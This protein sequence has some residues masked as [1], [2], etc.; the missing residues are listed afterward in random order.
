M[1]TGNI[2]F[3]PNRDNSARENTAEGSDPKGA[4]LL[5]ENKTTPT[6]K[7]WEACILVGVFYGWY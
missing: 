4:L 1:K 7:E 6:T 5:T 2:R 3:F